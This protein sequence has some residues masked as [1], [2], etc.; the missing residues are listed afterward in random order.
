MFIYIASSLAIISAIIIIVMI[1]FRYWEIKVG[2]IHPKDSVIEIGFLSSLY[3]AHKHITNK[4]VH[5]GSRFARF[6]HRKTLR[7]IYDFLTHHRVQKV[8]DMIKGKHKII[9]GG[10]KNNN[11]SVYLKNVTEHKNEVRKEQNDKK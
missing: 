5:H 2:R 8:T 3:K 9:E 11:A 4:S 10:K 7:L 6:A 1:L